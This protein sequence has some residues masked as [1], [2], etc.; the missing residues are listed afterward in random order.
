MNERLQDACACN[1]N[2]SGITIR[3]HAHPSLPTSFKEIW[4]TGPKAPPTKLLLRIKRLQ[5]VRFRGEDHD[6]L[7]QAVREGGSG[8]GSYCIKCHNVQK[9][10]QQT[11]MWRGDPVKIEVESMNTSTYWK[12]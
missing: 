6:H 11:P 2:H 10:H 12:L 5:Q 1:T 3:R 7:R 9:A 8:R 4:Y